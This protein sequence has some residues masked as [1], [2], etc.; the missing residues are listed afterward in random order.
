MRP[1]KVWTSQSHPLPSGINTL[2]AQHPPLSSSG[3]KMEL[4]SKNGIMF[5]QLYYSVIV[6]N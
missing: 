6:F 1:S 4:W 2:S 3:L 5:R